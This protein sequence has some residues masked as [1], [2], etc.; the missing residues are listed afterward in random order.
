MNSSVS[1][2]GLPPLCIYA[3]LFPNSPAAQTYQSYSIYRMEED[4]AIYPMSRMHAGMF[5]HPP[6]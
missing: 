5:W 4:G 3:S 1:L 2:P 6:L